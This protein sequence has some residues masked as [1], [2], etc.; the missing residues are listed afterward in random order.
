MTLFKKMASVNTGGRRL[1][2]ID[3]DED[4]KYI[5]DKELQKR[6]RLHNAIT[7]N[8]LKKR[9]PKTTSKRYLHFPE[10]LRKLSEIKRIFNIFDEDDSSKEHKNDHLY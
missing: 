4:D 9:F 5:N 3:Q 6:T 8:W 1:D 7:V 10:E 2:L